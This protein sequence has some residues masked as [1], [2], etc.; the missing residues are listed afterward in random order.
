MCLRSTCLGRAFFLGGKREC[1]REERREGNNNEKE[2][3]AKDDHE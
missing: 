1:G 2:V 3:V